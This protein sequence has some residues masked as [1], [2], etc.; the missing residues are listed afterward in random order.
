M[1][2]G[3]TPSASASAVPALGDH[4]LLH[5]L[6]LVP[7]GEHVRA[8]GQPQ[9]PQRQAGQRQRHVQQP[10]AASA[11]SQRQPDDVV[12][13]ERLGAGELEPAVAPRTAVGQRRR[14]PVGHVLGPDR[15]KTGLAG[16]RHR[17]GGQIGEA[18]EQCQPR[19]AGRVDDRRAEDGRLE[20]RGG[21]GL[22]GQGLGAEEA[23]AR[24]MRRPQRGEEEKAPRAGPLRRPY[25]AKSGHRVQL[26]DRS[27]RLV[28]DGRREVHDGAHPPQGVAK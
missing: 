27:A 24:V 2:S 13:G 5:Q 21:H 6:R 10:A 16:A 1:G 23:R 15:L 17:D 3:R 22:L 14:H 12:V 18:L 11:G 19:V 4:R 8:H 7:G 28:A 9:Q 20:R 26:L 25:E